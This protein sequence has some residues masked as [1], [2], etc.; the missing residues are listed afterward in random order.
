MCFLSSF[1]FS[2]F[3]LRVG[4][5][6]TDSAYYE[7]CAYFSMSVQYTLFFVLQLLIYYKNLKNLCLFS[8]E[9]VKKDKNERGKLSK[10]KSKQ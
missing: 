5:K 6:N 3:L 9:N 7:P 2:S 1:Q 8:F 4:F 10:K